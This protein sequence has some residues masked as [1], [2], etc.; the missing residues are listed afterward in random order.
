MR[1][2]FLRLQPLDAVDTPPGARDRGTVIHEAIGTFTERYKDRLPADP[3]EEL[4]RLGKEGFA[5]LEDFPDA[6]AFWWPRF[7]RVAR[8]FVDFEQRA[9]R[10]AHQA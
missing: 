10:P 9:P 7:Q 8:W 2:M 3:L 1:A 6:R 5:R 4:L